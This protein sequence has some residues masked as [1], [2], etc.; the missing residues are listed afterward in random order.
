MFYPCYLYL[1][2]YSGA[3][4]DFHIRWCSCRL[5]VTRQVSLVERELLALPEHMST[6]S[7]F[8][9][10]RVARSWTLYVVFCRSLF[11]LFILV[12]VFCHFS[13]YDFW[14]PLWYL[15]PFLRISLIIKK[16][17]T[18]WRRVLPF[19]SYFQFLSLLVNWNIFT[20][21]CFWITHHY[22]F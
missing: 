1:F 11:V 21:D 17:S 6:P 19:I 7:G 2:T 15:Q 22:I 9:G 16:K 13:I 5:A 10:I 12:I 14:L 3:Q 18:F 4:R 8:S 20:D